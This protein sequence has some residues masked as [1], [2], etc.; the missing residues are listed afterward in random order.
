MLL[1]DS[2]LRPFLGFRFLLNASAECFVSNLQPRFEQLWPE[3]VPCCSQSIHEPRPRSGGAEH[4]VHFSILTDPGAI[5]R[6]QILH[7][8]ALAFHARDFGDGNHLAAPV[9]QSC[10]LNDHVDGGGDL[11]TNGALRDIQI[12]H[13]KHAFES[14]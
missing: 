3:Q 8:D 13:R 6:K 4:T 9:G 5:E 7:P 12:R 11:L 10:D 2:A 1:V 14:G